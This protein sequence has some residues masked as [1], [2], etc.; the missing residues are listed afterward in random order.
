MFKYLNRFYNRYQTQVNAS[1]ALATFYTIFHKPINLAFYE[2]WQPDYLEKNPRRL[3]LQTDFEIRKAKI[4]QL[5]KDIDAAEDPELKAKLKQDLR[6]IHLDRYR[7]FQRIAHA[8]RPTE[9]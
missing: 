6:N 7:Q 4:I 2:I 9:E 1:I 8:P 5:V 3:K